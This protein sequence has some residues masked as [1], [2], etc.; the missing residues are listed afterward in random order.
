MT[1]K[2]NKKDGLPISPEA[3][4]TGVEQRTKSSSRPSS[5]VLLATVAG[6]AAS[7]GGEGA[8]CSDQL[9]IERGDCRELQVMLCCSYL[10]ELLLS[11]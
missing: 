10:R 4:A 1:P 6:G 11:L 5:P 7:G 2:G 9:S 8:S 3:A